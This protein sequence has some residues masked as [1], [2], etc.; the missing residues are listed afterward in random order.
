MCRTLHVARNPAFHRPAL[1]PAAILTNLLAF[2]RFLRVFSRGGGF[3]IKISE[4]AVWQGA[5]FYRQVARS[6]G[7]ED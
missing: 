7:A 4:S 1:R 5:C 2:F 6:S 3:D